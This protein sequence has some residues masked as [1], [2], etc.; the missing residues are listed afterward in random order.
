[1][2]IELP[3]SE[4]L[5]LQELS[6]IKYALDQS[7]MIVI[8]NEKGVITYVNE[9]FC[10]RSQ[11]SRN[12]LI[13][14]THKIVNSGFHPSEFFA[15][16]WSTITQ[17]QIWRGEIKNK[18]KDGSYYW[19]DSTIV[20]FLDQ[21]NKPWQ[22]LAIRYDITEAKEKQE[23]LAFQAKLLDEVEQAVIVTDLEGKI[24]YWNNYA[25]VLYGWSISD[26]IGKS[27]IEIT[28]PSMTKEQIAEIMSFLAQ[29]N[30]W[31]GEFEVQKKN[32][33]S[34]PAWIIDS[35]IHDAQGKFIGIIGL[36]IEISQKQFLYKA[37]KNSEQNFRQLAENIP[38]VFFIQNSDHSKIIYISSAYEKIW[39]R[40]CK[41]LYNE[42]D[43]WIESVYPEDLPW[44]LDNFKNQLDNKIPFTGE[45][46][47]IRP[48]GELRWIFVRSFF[49][50]DKTGNI[51]RTVGIA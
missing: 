40:S 28:I 37:L 15:N 47:I 51:E 49:I 41:S 34:F 25:Q 31:S 17:G 30:S 6:S 3:L 23:Q 1:M 50:F 39:G 44:L 18:A 46:R 7:A 20:P 11:Y 10:A 13:G 43:S 29:G 36:S 19:T 12:E 35:P 32:G 24:I 5:S 42:P 45:Y 38:E 26:V 14:K 22:Y 21:E 16:L 9:K 33:D 8:T 2:S 48:D 27:I 4:Q